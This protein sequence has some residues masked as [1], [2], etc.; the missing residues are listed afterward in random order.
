MSTE[1]SKKELEQELKKARKK[2]RE[3]QVSRELAEK[4]WNQTFNSLEE[5]IIVLNK[6]QTID[7]INHRGKAILDMPKEEII[8]KKCYHLFNCDQYKEHLCPLEESIKLKKP[9]SIYPDSKILNRW[10]FIQATPIL[11]ENQN[12]NKVIE[13][14]HDITSERKVMQQIKTQNKHNE[15]LNE[16]LNEQIEEYAALNEEYLTA[17]EELKANEEKYRD[18][19]DNATVGIFQTS[20]TGNPIII[21]K[22]MARIL[23]AS[24]E[25]DAL[26]RYQDLSKSLY[27]NPERRVEFINQLTRQGK[28][29]GFVYQAKTLKGERKWISMSARISKRMNDGT[30]IIDGFAADITKQKKAELDKAEQEARYLQLFNSIR[31]AIIVTDTKGRIIDFN[32]AFRL[33]FGYTRK[34]MLNQNT[35]FLFED[36]QTYKQT[37][38]SIQ[39]QLKKGLRKKLFIIR[40]KTKKEKI[41]PG[42]TTLFL[43]K[44]SQGN[45]QGY[46]GLI[47]DVSQRIKAEKEL[48]NQLEE[49]Q[50]LYEEY[51]TQ[52]EE[53]SNNMLA[54]QRINAELEKARAKA[55]ESDRL[56][57][58]FLANM[59]HEIRTPMNGIIG[60]SQV[61]MNPDLPHEKRENYS[62]IIVNSS[63]QLLNIV[64]DL[65]DISSIETGQIKIHKKELSIPQVLKEFYDLYKPQAEKQN[66][67]FKLKTDPDDQDL[68]LITDHTRFRQILTN[69]LNNALKFTDKGY[70]HFGY[71]EEKNHILFYIEDSGPGIPE[72]QQEKI[73]ERFIQGNMTPSRSHGGTGLGL[74]ISKR[75][76]E[77]MGGTISVESTPGKGSTFSFLLPK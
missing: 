43:L 69:L 34:E 57:S 74:S 1:T 44:D 60:F 40:Y 31:D 7:D 65:L 71:K 12:V 64:N 6:D 50:A 59:S 29:E 16:Q 24:S 28:V 5:V 67:A 32:P 17:N 26:D 30:F 35:A 18:L 68:T 72:E 46:I 3:E 36:Q 20:S 76:V 56:K 49:Y 21:N 2:I 37:I 73:F 77:L 15:E 11:D 70:I 23:G 10:F 63:E 53:L 39:N 8:G 75:L 22:E 41:F 58:A 42:E 51:L 38:A 19:F 54:L 66:L 62:R 45:E 14:M 61:L 4:K 48:T 52:N 25:Q 55:E 33:L 13:I 47:R 27:V 9:I